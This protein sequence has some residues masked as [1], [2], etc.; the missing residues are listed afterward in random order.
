MIRVG[1]AVRK[2][3]YPLIQVELGVETLFSPVPTHPNS[4]LAHEQ[5]DFGQVG[6]IGPV[7]F[8]E[9]SI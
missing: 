3:F 7:E 6:T 8:A 2:L 4:L 9:L 1:L 5:A